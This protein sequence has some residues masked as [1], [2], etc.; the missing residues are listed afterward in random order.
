VTVEHGTNQLLGLSPDRIRE[1]PARL[2]A[3]AGHV[4]RVPPLW[5]GAAAERL[6]DIL[7]QAPLDRRCGHRYP[8]GVG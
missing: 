2:V 6:A 4:A 1:I 8:T 5:D 3:T 7:E